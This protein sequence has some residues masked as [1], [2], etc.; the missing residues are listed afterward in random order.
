MENT[1]SRSHRVAVTPRAAATDIR[2]DELIVAFDG[3]RPFGE[4]VDDYAAR[5]DLDP[6]EAFQHVETIACD[7]LRQGL[8]GTAP[9]ETRAYPGRAQLLQA[10][11]LKE[12]WLHTNNSCN[13]TCRHCL[14]SSGP[15][16]DPGL[17]TAALLDVLAQARALGARRFYFTGGEPVI[18]KD[19]TELCR[20]VL[21]DPEAELA[22]LTNGIMLKGE[23]LEALA[24]LDHERLRLQVSIDGS[25]PEVND[26]IRG[27]GPGL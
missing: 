26:P 23:R 2:G 1:L 11:E 15:D 6:V 16:G 10:T 20:F 21:D 14:V 18:R 19:I 7:A 3:H 5:H 22:I 9:A 4:V 27:E 24:A 17:P 12:L 13:L 25:R 8:L